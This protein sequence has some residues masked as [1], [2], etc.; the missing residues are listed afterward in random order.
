MASTAGGGLPV[1]RRPDVLEARC[2]RRVHDAAEHE[3]IDYRKR[4]AKENCS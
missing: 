2:R 3:V 1:R 4:L